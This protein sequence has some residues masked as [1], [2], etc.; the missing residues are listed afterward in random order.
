[1]MRTTIYLEDKDRR[2]LE[3]IQGRYG[4]AT[5][6]DAIRFSVPVVQGLAPPKTAIAPPPPPRRAVPP[7]PGASTVGGPLTQARQSGHAAAHV[8][9]QTRAFLDQRRPGRPEGG[10]EHRTAQAGL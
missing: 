10:I 5:L 7:P 8:I 1:V 6:S 9:A 4:V 3:G 2:A